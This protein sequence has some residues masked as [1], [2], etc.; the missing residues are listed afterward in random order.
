MIILFSK[1]SIGLSQC[2]YSVDSCQRA[3]GD[4]DLMICFYR[5][6]C[7]RI[8]RIVIPRNFSLMLDRPDMTGANHHVIEVDRCGACDDSNFS[9]TRK[10][11]NVDNGYFF[12][13][14]NLD[15]STRCFFDY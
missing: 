8:W 3:A 15:R 2:L 4:S 5:E 12:K 7:R 1:A 11:L 10:I 6:L 14:L 13:K 9:E